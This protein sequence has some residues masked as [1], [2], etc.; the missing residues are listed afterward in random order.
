MNITDDNAPTS[1]AVG[2]PVERQVRPHGDIE[3]AARAVMA[4]WDAAQNAP[5]GCDSQDGR[6]YWT[7]IFAAIDMLREALRPN[8]EL[9]GP[10]RPARKDEDG[11]E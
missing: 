6:D 10:Q 9:S 7:A 8:V 4:A 3:T 2:L 1:P 5:L 11:T